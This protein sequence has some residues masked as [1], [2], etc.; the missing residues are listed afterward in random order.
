ML[1]PSIETERLTL[2]FLSKSES[3]L[4]IDYYKRNKDH[5]GKTMPAFGPSFFEQTHWENKIKQYTSEFKD[6]SS[7]RFFILPKN[8]N[9]VIGTISFTDI[10]RGVYQGCFLGYGIDKEYEGKGLM[11]EALKPLI[12]YVFRELNIHK[13]LANYMPWNRPSGRVLEKLGFYEV[14][15]AKEELYLAGKW[16]DHIETRLINPGWKNIDKKIDQTE[17]IVISDYKERWPLQFLEIK[18]LLI[19]ALGDLVFS[20]DHIGST[21]IPG[22]GAKDR[23]DVQITVN[24][25]TDEL[26]SQLDFKLIENKFEKS[27][28]YSDHRPP[29]DNSTEK[30]WKKL[31]FSGAHPDL[32][33]KSNI[34]VRILGHE[35]QKYSLLFRDYLRTNLDSMQAYETLKKELSLY[36]CFDRVAYCEI[37]DPACDL[38]MVSAREWANNTGWTIE[39]SLEGRV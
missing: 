5:L 1:L 27:K 7:C 23:I 29:G 14:G 9:I 18:N 20:I 36:H 11:T 31:Y 35:N 6:G 32:D 3:Q 26:K 12:E 30:N 22:L 28:N 37:K 16:Q 34:H 33:F 13:L 10:V 8:K 21:S 2:R 38:I 17:P 19:N 15:L 39:E 4:A 24:E 25:I